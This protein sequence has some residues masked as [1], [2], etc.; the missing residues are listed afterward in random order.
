MLILVT[1][2]QQTKLGILLPI[3]VRVDAICW[4]IKLK[5]TFFLAGQTN[6]LSFFQG[7]SLLFNHSTHNHLQIP[8]ICFHCFKSLLRGFIFFLTSPKITRT[9]RASL[10]ILLQTTPEGNTVFSKLMLED[11]QLHRKL[12][13]PIA[14]IWIF[15]P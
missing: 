13:D 5:T 14:F 12:L 2:K 6:K 11:K 1:C 15:T 8:N 3:R 9:Y 10:N 4:Q 7:N